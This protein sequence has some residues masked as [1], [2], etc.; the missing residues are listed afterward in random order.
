MEVDQLRKRVSAQ[1]AMPIGMVVFKIAGRE[2]CFDIRFLTG[3]LKP[4]ELDFHRPSDAEHPDRYVFDG[5]DYFLTDIGTFLETKNPATC[6]TSWILLVEYRKRRIAFQVDAVTE[7]IT[8]IGCKDSPFR[9]VTTEDVPYR[10]GYF[11]AL[12][13][14]IWEIDLD[15]VI[16]DSPRFRPAV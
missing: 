11:E 14:K 4:G 6:D 3:S 16:K 10:R 8:G 9:F 12:I 13:R 1:V 2:F 5:Q 15:S 7:I